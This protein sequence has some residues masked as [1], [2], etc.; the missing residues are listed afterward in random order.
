MSQDSGGD[1]D[2]GFKGSAEI[3]TESVLRQ[4]RHP[5][6]SRSRRK[7]QTNEH[8]QHHHHDKKLLKV[9]S[10]LEHSASSNAASKLPLPQMSSSSTT[11]TTITGPER[12]IPVRSDERA[13]TSTTT[14]NSE[15]KA[16]KGRRHH[17]QHFWPSFSQSHFHLERL[18]EGYLPSNS[19]KAKSLFYELAEADRNKYF[20][21]FQEGSN[22]HHHRLYGA[23]SLDVLYAPRQLT[24]SQYP[25]SDELRSL[26][27]SSLEAPESVLKTHMNA[28]HR[29]LDQTVKLL[30]PLLDD[31]TEIALR[32]R[33][34]SER[35]AKMLQDACTF[36]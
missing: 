18:S 1:R 32:V 12:I 13:I 9:P 8:H 36:D 23:K 2:S 10:R 6:L 26:L 14:G 15:D 29:S 4:Q 33:A 17:Q 28:Q 19:I 34:K 3:D 16:S 30:D 27:D 25:N 24:S 5:S 22:R 20:G 31:A 35:L 21:Y 7:C 11:T